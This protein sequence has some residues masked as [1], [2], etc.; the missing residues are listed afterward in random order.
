MLNLRK[1]AV[2]GG[3]SSGKT[4]VCR[5]FQQLGAY[6]V[7]ADQITHQLLSS[8]TSLRQQLITF[9]GDAIL[10]DGLID[11][12]KMAK[13]VFESPALL[14]KAE[15]LIHPRV[16]ERI[17]QEWQKAVSEQKYPLFIVE[18]PLLFEASMQHGY[19][20]S[21]AVVSEEAACIKRFCMSGE[22]GKAEYF[23]RA[24]RQLPQSEKAKK[25]VYIINNDGT[26]PE[27]KEK[28]ASL[29]HVIGVTL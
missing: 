11:R 26:L 14:R 18:I 23:S 29:Y 28:V 2:T 21:I 3:L 16:S 15:E 12:S 19:D 4:T 24:S 5:M 10:T 1:I 22:H 9:L 20:A 27:L 6:I 25:A 7:N 8:D 13:V 17:E